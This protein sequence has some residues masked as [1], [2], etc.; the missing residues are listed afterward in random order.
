MKIIE[1]LSYDEMSQTAADLIIKQIEEKSSS[2]LGLAT[3]GT[4]VGVYQKLVEDHYLNG[5]SYRQVSTVNLDEYVG[6]NETDPNSYRMYMNKQFFN[7]VDI[8]IR[9][10]HLPNG[11]AENLEVECGMYEKKI[12][13]LG[14]VDLQLLGIGENG[15]I[16]FNEPG[17]P[18]LSKTHVVKLMDSTRHANA[19]YFPSLECVPT[20]AITMGID[21]IFQSKKIVLLASG[22]KKSDAVLQLLNEKVHDEFPASILHQHNEVTL[23]ADQDALS[24][25]KR[26][27][28]SS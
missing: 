10:T 14:R 26:T 3:G 9:Q 20:H 21:S 8:P 7:H 19:K 11:M 12:N 22:I 18:F 15:H 13:Q 5:T 2:V 28:F 4:M 27:A 24:L 6:I 16:G 25:V 17:T 23:I 1:V